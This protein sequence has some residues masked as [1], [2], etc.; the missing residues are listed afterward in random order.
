MSTGATRALTFGEIVERGGVLAQASRVTRDVIRRSDAGA[1]EDARVH[2]YVITCDTCTA[3]KACCSYVTTAYLHEAI[4]IAA[5]LIRERRDTPTLRKR[6]R[7]VAE[8]MEAAPSLGLVSPCVFLDPA[9]RCSIYEDR[10]SVCGRHL[11]SSDPALCATPGAEV[12]AI[13]VP[14]DVDVRGETAVEVADGLGLE[15][16][17]TQYCGM[18]P[19]MVLLCLEAWTRRDFARFLARHGRAAAQRMQALADRAAQT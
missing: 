1:A 7:D 12:K 4:P 8:Q 17:G 10:P 16:I 14:L 3:S 11:V 5:R 19:R 13:Q 2:L 9:E 15:P 18:M 6:L